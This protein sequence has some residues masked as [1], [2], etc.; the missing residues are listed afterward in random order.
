M[1]HNDCIPPAGVLQ[2]P[3][4]PKPSRTA[5]YHH[6]RQIPQTATL[7][8][9]TQFGSVGKQMVRNIHKTRLLSELSCLE[10]GL[11]LELLMNVFVTR[12]SPSY[13]SSNVA[14]CCR[15]SGVIC[16]GYSS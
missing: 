6:D 12:Y 10:A 9:K 14:I 7:L 1:M 3:H 8:A 4:A 2:W 15:S 16:S 13:R 11:S 5:T